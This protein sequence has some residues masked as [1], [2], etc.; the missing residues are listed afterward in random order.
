MVAETGRRPHQRDHLSE[1]SIHASSIG[2][3]IRRHH[4][5]FH[6]GCGVFRRLSASQQRFGGMAF[7]RTG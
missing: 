6:E 7:E 3:S 4:E 5:T 2:D 1:H